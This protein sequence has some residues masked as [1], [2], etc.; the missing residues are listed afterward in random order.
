[1][2]EVARRTDETW[3]A[4]IR[5][6]V[7]GLTELQA[8]EGLEAALVA[9]GVKPACCI[10]ASGSITASPHHNAGERVIQPAAPWAGTT[11]MSRAPRTWVQR[12]QRTKLLTPPSW[13]RMRSRS[14]LCSQAFPAKRSTGP[15]AIT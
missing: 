12:P 1:M 15:H 13:R 6:P 7:A 2:A 10:V 3:E 8:K 4:F 9:R 11:R 5:Q 14:P